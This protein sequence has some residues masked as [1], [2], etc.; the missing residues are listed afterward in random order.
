MA[1][2]SHKILDLIGESNIQISKML[3]VASQKIPYRNSKSD[4]ENPGTIRFTVACCT[5]KDQDVLHLEG[6]KGRTS[7]DKHRL[8]R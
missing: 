8:N 5:N 4:S 1:T 3:E 6:I 7:L 2:W